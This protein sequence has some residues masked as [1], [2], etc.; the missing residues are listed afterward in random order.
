MLDVNQH[1]AELET[2]CDFT[3]IFDQFRLVDPYTSEIYMLKDETAVPTGEGPCF[4]IWNRESPCENC[5]S[6]R[7]CANRS[8]F[9][10]LEYFRGSVLMVIAKPIVVQ[11]R[12]FS[13]ELATNVTNS[14]FVLDE[15]HGE[16]TVISDLLAKFNRLSISDFFTGLYNNLYIKNQIIELCKRKDGH[17]F[18]ILIIDIDQFKQVNDRHGHLA[19]DMVIQKIAQTLQNLSTIT[20]C[21]VGRMGGDE[22]CVVFRGLALSEAERYAQQAVSTIQE[23]RYEAQGVAFTVKVSVG[24]GE[25]QPGEEPFAFIERVDHALYVAK[26]IKGKPRT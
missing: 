18:S 25:Y 12:L 13:L 20:D 2:L 1:K 16:Q 26:R 24:I 8:Q 10:K 17:P 23:Q 14:M 3:G 7:A 6:Q 19:G 11:G 4:H 5:I 22:Y 9:M 21:C 15:Y